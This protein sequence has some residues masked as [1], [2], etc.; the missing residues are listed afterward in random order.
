MTSHDGGEESDATFRSV[1]IACEV[2]KVQYGL[3]DAR[4][5]E[6]STRECANATM[7]LLREHGDTAGW[8]TDFGNTRL[9]HVAGRT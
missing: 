4:E 1:D 9:M 6:E 3:R 5:I 7:G 2:E 8:L